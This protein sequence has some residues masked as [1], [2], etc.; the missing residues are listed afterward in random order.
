MEKKI[1]LL[2][3]LLCII[4]ISIFFIPERV[5]KLA[6]SP[7]K[8]MHGE[9][10]RFFTYPFAHLNAK[11][12]IENIIGALLIG[13]IATELKIEFGYM[14]IIYLL[15]GFLAVLPLWIVWQFVA[16]GASTAIFGGF[17]LI[18]RET[19]KYQMNSIIVF[20]I[21][22]AFIFTSSVFRL[23]S[24][25]VDEQFLGSLKQDASHFS[26]FLFG[27]ISYSGALR[28][29]HALTKHKRHLL[30]GIAR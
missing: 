9:W 28:V 29:N 14:I 1:I 12:L 23:F 6:L 2:M 24:G 10:W 26:G 19:P 5:D 17:G 16:L 21:V 13:I 25:G 27:V 15:A 8:A 7:E 22:I 30:R 20:M 11:H 3:A 18:S 4:Y